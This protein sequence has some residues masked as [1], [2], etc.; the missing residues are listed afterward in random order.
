MFTESLVG[1]TNIS[2]TTPHRNNGVTGV[3]AAIPA[4]AHDAS[5][6][7]YQTVVLPALQACHAALITAV[8]YPG[9]LSNSTGARWGMGGVGVTL[10]QT[11]ATPNQ[12]TAQF[13]A[14][15]DHCLG[16][17]IYSSNFSNAQSNHPGGCNVL[18]GDGSV[19][20]V[21]DSI[22]PLMWMAIGT[23]ANGEVV[24]SDSY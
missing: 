23:R 10:M 11:V 21:K 3:T 5:A 1:D 17:G 18:F 14:C 4:R 6:L 16:C 19:R 2:G 7:N 24:S 9:G 13:N 22:S 12:T 15:Y 8:P 20:F